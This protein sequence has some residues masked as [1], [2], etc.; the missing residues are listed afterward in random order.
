MSLLYDNY[1]FAQGYL[2]VDVLDDRVL[3]DTYRSVKYTAFINGQC[4]YDTEGKAITGYM[5]QKIL[6]YVR[7]TQEEVEEKQRSDFFRQILEAEKS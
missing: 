3:E 5:A 6:A 1:R 7:Q 4:V 2:I